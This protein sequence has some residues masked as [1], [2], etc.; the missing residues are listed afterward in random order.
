MAALRWVNVRDIR[1]D[2]NMPRQTWDSAQSRY[3]GAENGRAFII[4]DEAGE[5]IE[6]GL[7][8]LMEKHLVPQVMAHAASHYGPEAHGANDNRKQHTNH[9][10]QH[11]KPHH[12]AH[13]HS[14]SHTTKVVNGKKVED[15]TRA[16]ENRGEGWVERVT[17]N[18]AAEQNTAMGI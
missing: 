6:E 4:Q 16:A 11:T 18:L 5:M 17:D 2:P 9:Q 7:N 10:S 3:H 12:E 1:K 15:V 8:R 14:V 13:G